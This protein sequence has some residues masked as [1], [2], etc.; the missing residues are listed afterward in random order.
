MG[1]RPYYLSSLAVC[2]T[3]AGNHHAHPLVEIRHVHHL[4]LVPPQFA[5]GPMIPPCTVPPSRRIGSFWPT[6]TRFN[7]KGIWN[8]AQRPPV[9]ASQSGSTEHDATAIRIAPHFTPNRR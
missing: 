5:A 3:V 6:S 4:D 2:N 9:A 1:I 7:G 8:P